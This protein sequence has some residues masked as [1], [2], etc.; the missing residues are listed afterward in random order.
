MVCIVATKWKENVS[1]HKKAARR[2]AEH[3]DKTVGRL[4]ITGRPNSS[5]WFRIQY[6]GALLTIQGPGELLS[7]VYYIVILAWACLAQIGLKS[8][9]EITDNSFPDIP[10]LSPL[11]LSPSQLRRRNIFSRDVNRS[12]NN[13][14]RNPHI[15]VWNE[16]HKRSKD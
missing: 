12:E 14:N 11:S 4:L 16:T 1:D 15:V 8:N 13:V 3:F 5:K 2:T 9:A 7:T 6:D 10:C